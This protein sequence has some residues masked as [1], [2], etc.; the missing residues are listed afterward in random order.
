M[1]DKPKI[2]QYARI[3]K[4]ILYYHLTLLSAQLLREPEGSCL[5]HANIITVKDLISVVSNLKKKFG[6][7]KVILMTSSERPRSQKYRPKLIKP[8]PINTRIIHLANPD[9]ALDEVPEFETFP[10]IESVGLMGWR[11]NV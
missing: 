1:F 10:V 8:L 11:F 4:G 3:S 2:G 6:V 7:S 9:L 5:W